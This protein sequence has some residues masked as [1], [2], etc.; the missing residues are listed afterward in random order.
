MAKPRQSMLYYI[1][2]TI[3]I[4]SLVLALI[5]GFRFVR[6]ARVHPRPMIRQTDVTLIQTWMSLPYVSEVYGV[7]MHEFDQALNLDKKNHFETIEKLA[8]VQGKTTD[9][10]LTEIQQI[11]TQFQTTHSP[12]P[13]P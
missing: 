3:S 9:T 12:P 2:V 1:L 5:L 8:R 13:T 6:L 10:L 11:I 4:I 7:P